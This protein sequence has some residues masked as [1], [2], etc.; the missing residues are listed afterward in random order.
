MGVEFGA[1]SA[2]FSRMRRWV[3]WLTL[4]ACLLACASGHA[5]T[6]K[7]IKVLPQLL[8]ERGRNSRSPSLY[9][10]DAYQFYLRQHTNQIAGMQFAVQWKAKGPGSG[11]VKLRVEARGVARG[12][13]PTEM[14]IEKWVEAGGWGW[15]STWTMVFVG[16]EDFKSLGELTAWRV[17]LWEGDRQV[18]EQ[19][20]F[21]W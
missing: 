16:K 5:A 1:G 12:N 11:W 21:L 3:L 20:S 8:D 13:L 4:F 14:T 10:R 6:S 9:E 7:V 15:F 19:Q 18:G 17:T 2:Y